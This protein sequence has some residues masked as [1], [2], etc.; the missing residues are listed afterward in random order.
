MSDHPAD[1]TPEPTNTDPSVE[2]AG[3]G[4]S[5]GADNPAWEPIRSAVDENTYT[6]IKPHLS[7]FDQ[8]AQRRI[9]SVNEKFGWAGK[10]T[11]NGMTAEEVQQAVTLAQQ[12]SA[13]PVDVFNNLK[14][15]LEQYYPD[16]FAKLDWIARQQE[17]AAGQQPGEPSG[18]EEDPRI[19]ELQRRQDALDAQGQQQQQ[20]F[21]Q[22][23]AQRMYDQAS[24][25]ID[26]E[27]KKISAERPDLKKEDWAEIMGYAGSKTL[28]GQKPVTVTEAVAWFDSIANRIRTAPRP[29]DSAPSLLP[30]GGGNPGSPQKVDYANMSD[31]D[32]QAMIVA[33]MEAKNKQR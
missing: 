14:G 20:F 15:Y 18:E 5:P 29:S 11:E 26:A 8:E 3:G 22:Q 12:I 10:L 19:A 33:D 23:E 30:L 25:Q 13:S 21:E 6:L 24:S 16:E 17:A 7:K 27:Y 1:A 2:P 9:Q 4:E 31:A 32:I 28:E